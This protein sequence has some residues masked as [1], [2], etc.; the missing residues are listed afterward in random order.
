MGEDAGVRAIAAAAYLVAAALAAWAS[1]TEREQER[2]FWVVT[3]AIL[4]LLGAAKQLQVQGSLTGAF[5][6][7]AQAGG[8]YESHREVQAAFAAIAIMFSL[9]A[10][11]ACGRWL[12]QCAGSVK[13]AAALLGSLLVFLALRLAS[14]HAVDTWTIA[15]IAGV[16]RGWWVELAATMLIA[17]CATVYGAVQTR[18]G[19]VAP[20]SIR[21]KGSA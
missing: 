11:L 15:E 18:S 21:R 17:A 3:V 2:R 12:R 10:G 6:Q 16:R 5:R 13:A 4:I 8:W 1:R 20:A 14:I 19:R 9:S 7:L